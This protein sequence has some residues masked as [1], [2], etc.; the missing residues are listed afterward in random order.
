MHNPQTQKTVGD[1]QREGWRGLGGGGQKGGGLGTPVIM[2]KIKCKKGEINRKDY[3][4]YIPDSNT[5]QDLV[6][7]K[8]EGQ[9][10]C[11]ASLV[12][13]CLNELDGT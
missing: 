11:V 2:S 3:M 9:S 12:T 7:G 5:S 13:W 1:G 8:V 6:I 4:K 10:G